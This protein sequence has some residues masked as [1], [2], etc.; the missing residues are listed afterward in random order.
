MSAIEP[1]AKVVRSTASASIGGPARS[2]SKPSPAV[3]IAGTIVI[4]ADQIGFREVVTSTHG[5]D[6]DVIVTLPEAISER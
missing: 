6:K 3:R 4:R 2:G 5:V 1:G